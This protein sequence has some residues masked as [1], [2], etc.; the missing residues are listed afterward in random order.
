VRVKRKSDCSEPSTSV[1]SLVTRKNT[2]VSENNQ[3]E[4]HEEPITEDWIK[5]T[6]LRM[7]AQRW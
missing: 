3:G 1:N 2:R 4:E 5:V 7:M 6:V